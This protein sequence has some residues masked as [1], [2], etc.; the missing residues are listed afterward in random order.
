MFC[1]GVVAV[2][3]RVSASNVGKHSWA[4][5]CRILVLADIIDK[6]NERGVTAADGVMKMMY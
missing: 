5:A 1:G 6:R 3:L 4:C 2:C